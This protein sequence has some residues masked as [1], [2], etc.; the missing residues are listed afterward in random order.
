M[1]ELSDRTQTV[2]V[3]KDFPHPPEKVWRALTQRELIADWLME[4]DFAPEPGHRFTMRG[5]WGSV[6]CEVL[7]AARDRTLSYAW[8]GMGIETVVT[9]T[10]TPSATGTSLR[11][12][13]SGF[14]TE[15][16]RAYDGAKYGWQG[17]FANLG[18]LLARGA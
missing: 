10:L 14:R 4:N 3:E 13:Q 7:E 16:V 18:N 5:D 12:E 2:V 1:N 15:Q 11:M 9:W 17:F 8:V 6:Q